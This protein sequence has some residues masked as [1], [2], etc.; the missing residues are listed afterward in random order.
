MVLAVGEEC[1]IVNKK[2]GSSEDKTRK[3]RVELEVFQQRQH[4]LRNSNAMTLFSPLLAAK[5]LL[6]SNVSGNSF[7]GLAVAPS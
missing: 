1:L 5:S 7:A 3:E 6:A 4:S 2:V